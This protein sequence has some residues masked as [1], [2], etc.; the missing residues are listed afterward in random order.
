MLIFTGIMTIAD[1]Y[2][3]IHITHLIVQPR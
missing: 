3:L 1:V 2:A